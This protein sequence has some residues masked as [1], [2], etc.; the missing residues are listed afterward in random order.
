[1]G[2][3][4]GEE[5]DKDPV[6]GRYIGRYITVFPQH[7]STFCGKLVDIVEGH[8]VL[9]PFLG[10]DYDPK[11][12][13]TF[14]LINRDSIIDCYKIVT[15]EPTTKRNLENYCEFQNANNQKENR[16]D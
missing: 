4:R 11:K 9:N 3:A 6:Y 2:F 8:L 14:R 10:R 12:G 7:G 15:V 5:S 16:K 13:N 1:M